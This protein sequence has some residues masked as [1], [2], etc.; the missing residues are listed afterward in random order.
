MKIAAQ[1]YSIFGSCPS[2]PSMPPSPQPV[3]LPTAQSGSEAT[4]G[5]FLKDCETRIQLRTFRHHHQGDT[6]CIPATTPVL[7]IQVSARAAPVDTDIVSLQELARD[8]EAYIH[9]QSSLEPTPMVD[10][11]VCRPHRGRKQVFGVAIVVALTSPPSSQTGKTKRL[12]YFLFRQRL[13]LTLAATSADSTA[14][15]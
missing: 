15:A 12:S 11:F 8:I 10:Q 14:R 6:I 13:I 2:D 9:R 1:R 5:Y 4:S 7:G 3:P